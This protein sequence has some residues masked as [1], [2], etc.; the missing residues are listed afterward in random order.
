[1]KFSQKNCA[2]HELSFQAREHQIERVK[3]IRDLGV[4]FFQNYSWDFHNDVI[5][6]K[7]R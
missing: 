3:L 5:V 6:K 1:M 4:N 7:A 2:D